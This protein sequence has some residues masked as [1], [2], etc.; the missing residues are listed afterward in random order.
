MSSEP[1]LGDRLGPVGGPTADPYE[2]AHQEVG[3]NA[4]GEPPTGPEDPRRP[5]E[6]GRVSL[7]SDHQ[8]GL[9]VGQTDVAPLDGLLTPPTSPKSVLGA[10]ARD[11]PAQGQILPLIRDDHR[12]RLLEV[13]LDVASLPRREGP[14]ALAPEGGS[15]GSKNRV[16]L[17]SC[18]GLIRIPADT[19]AGLSLL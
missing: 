15:T 1:A 18:D 10:V 16:G 17:L 14:E 12:Y 2:R 7:T 8:D 13:E 9:R 4:R 11:R 3:G 5:R 6:L 19:R